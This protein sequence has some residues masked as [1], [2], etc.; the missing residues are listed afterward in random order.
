MGARKPMA[1]ENSADG[2]ST[3]CSIYS[4]VISVF[5]R[6]MLVLFAV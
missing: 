6:I 2:L 1:P 5:A 4:I 3:V